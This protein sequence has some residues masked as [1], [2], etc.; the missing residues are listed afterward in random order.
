MSKKLSAIIGATWPDQA[1]CA[2]TCIEGGPPVGIRGNGGKTR[3]LIGEHKPPNENLAPL[4]AKTITERGKLATR[5][6]ISMIENAEIV[7]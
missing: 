4:A 2:R 6:G 5:D 7:K 1:G 3:M